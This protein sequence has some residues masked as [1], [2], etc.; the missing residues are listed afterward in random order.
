MCPRFLMDTWNRLPGFTD[1]TN[2]AM[3]CRPGGG[4]LAPG[5]EKF[6]PINYGINRTSAFHITKSVCNAIN[7]TYSNHQTRGPPII[8]TDYDIAKVIH[9]NRSLRVTVLRQ[10]MGRPFTL[11]PVAK[12]ALAYAAD[13]IHWLHGQ[14]YTTCQNIAF[15]MCAVRGWLRG[16][17]SST[18]YL[19]SPGVGIGKSCEPCGACRPDLSWDS[20]WITKQEYCTL[21]RAC[22]N[23]DEVLGNRTGFWRCVPNIGAFRKLGMA[24]D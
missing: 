12:E 7:W 3:A 2:D 8:G 16:Q 6:R 15:I 1:E 10:R 5:V 4:W 18:F 11:N 20:C 21:A 9:G 24:L 17:R 19:A 13:P 14:L 23:G 22:V